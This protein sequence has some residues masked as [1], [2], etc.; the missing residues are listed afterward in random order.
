MRTKQSAP[1]IT[2]SALRL[3][4]DFPLLPDEVIERF[5][6]LVEW[7]QAAGRFWNQTQNAMQDFARAVLDVTE[8]AGVFVVDGS[9]RAIYVKGSRDQGAYADPDTP[10]Y[11]DAAG[12]FSLGTSL[13]WNPETKTLT[14]LGSFVVT[15][16]SIGGFD[17]GPD[18][19]RDA[20][21]TFGLSSETSGSPNVRFWAGSTFAA[22]D[23][24]P[25]RVYDD[26]AMAASSGVIGGWAISSTTL[27]ANNAVLDSTGQLLLG[28]GNDVAIL[29]A[30]N[31]TYRLWIGNATAGTA[32]FSVTKAGAVFAISGTVGGF[33][34]GATSLTAGTGPTTISLST[35]VTAGLSVGDPTGLRAIHRA[36]TG[37]T[38]AS[39][40]LFN[41]ANALVGSFEV[42]SGHEAPN[43]FLSNTAGTQT[44]DIDIDKFV[45]KSTITFDGDTNIYRDSADTLKTD[46]DFIVAGN[47]TVGGT[48]SPASIT[49]GAI[50]GTTGAFSSN[51][52]IGG[53]LS[54]TGAFSPTSVSTGAISGTTGTFSS[55]VSI[56]GTLTVSGAFS[57]SSVS[58]G[59]ISGTTGSFSSN[60]SI[61]GTTTFTGGVTMNS[62]FFSIGS[63]SI[64]GGLGLTGAVTTG[65]G[66]LGAPGHAFASDTDTGWRL[67]SAGDMRGV[68]SGAD[69]LVV[70]DAAI[71]LL[72]PLKFD[73]NKAAGSPTPGGTVSAQDASGTTIQLITT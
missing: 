64:L 9:Q 30:T 43:I 36:G 22:R 26:G 5:P 73:T 50:S 72:V 28:T 65:D 10:F 52:T 40:Y 59:A 4:G 1:Q 11:A 38:S 23:T 48:Y 55:N 15:G 45:S 53:T 29:S 34:L 49:T 2:D 31:A 17:I 18:Y 27:A 61:T 20:S 33:T 54:V 44:I 7:N 8:L 21:D 32:A 37:G 25:F 19:I 63:C 42:Q 60:V 69:R 56:T 35:V 39:F 24:A 13:T 51:V 58:T 71:V 67:N 41:S 16:G 6:S 57:P 66:S 46:D 14:V 3:P 68:T 70:R 47:L 12:Y 62:G